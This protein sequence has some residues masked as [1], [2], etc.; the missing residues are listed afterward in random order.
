MV[1]EKEASYKRSLLASITSNETVDGDTQE[2]CKN[3]MLEDDCDDSR[4]RFVRNFILN[5]IKQI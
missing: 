1:R 3:E 4:F 5:L 2:S